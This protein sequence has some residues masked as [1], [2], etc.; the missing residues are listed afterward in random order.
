MKDIFSHLNF[1]PDDGE[2]ASGGESTVQEETEIQDDEEVDEEV[3]TETETEA[4][5]EAEDGVEDGVDEEAEDGVEVQSDGEYEFELSEDSSV[6][7][8]QLEVIADYAKELNM[9]QEEAQNFV[10]LQE[11]MNEVMQNT[12]VKQAQVS[13]ENQA[14]EWRKEIDSDPE[15]GGKNSEKT[16]ENINEAL[17]H[18]IPDQKQRNEYIDFLDQTGFGDYPMNVKLLNHMGQVLRGTPYLTGASIGSGKETGL[19]NAQEIKNTLYPEFKN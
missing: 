19:S 12:F 9:S 8:E 14:Q 1:F 15:L 16:I 18:L 3:E 10:F 7:D 6:S 13:L 5:A 11:N 2:Q 17:Q 4:E